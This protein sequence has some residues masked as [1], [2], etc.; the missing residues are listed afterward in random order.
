MTEHK[1]PVRNKLVPKNEHQKQLI[2]SIYENKITL[3]S[4]P[5]GTGKTV[6]P[7][8]VAAQ[9]LVEGKI[10]K[11]VLTRPIVES[12]SKGKSKLGALPGSMEEKIHPY[13][14]PLFEELSYFL[15]KDEVA[16]FKNNW[17]FNRGEQY[18]QIEILPLEVARG[19]TFKNT[20]V[21][22]DEAQ[23]ATY[24][25][26]KLLVTR[27]GENSRMVISGDESQS[28][29]S[30][31]DYGGLVRF[32]NRLEGV[33]GVGIVKFT[34]ADIV[35]DPIISEILDALEGKVDGSKNG[36]GKPLSKSEPDDCIR[37]GRNYLS[38]RFG[39]GLYE[40]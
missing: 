9:M 18:Q 13:L 25:Q 40:S 32:M 21:I 20:F 27:F 34:R 23:N 30:F 15:T 4:G 33:N 2:K 6:V 8:S 35:R 22:L 16:T 10:T 37:F 17:K 36:H 28:D 24:D 3:A 38:E 39:E 1:S 7:I 14:V 19:R 5:A 12:G 11:I 31:E 29:L 26:I